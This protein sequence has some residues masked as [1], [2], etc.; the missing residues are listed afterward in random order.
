MVMVRYEFDQQMT[1]VRRKDE[2]TDVLKTVY[3]PPTFKSTFGGTDKY[4]RSQ[5]N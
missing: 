2:K 5:I 1:E 4:K 3:P